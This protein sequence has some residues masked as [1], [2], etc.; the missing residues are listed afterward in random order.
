MNAR[1]R[2]GANIDSDH[3]LVEPKISNE[4]KE[5]RYNVGELN[6]QETSCKFGNTSRRS[7]E[8]EFRSNVKNSIS[9]TLRK[10][11]QRSSRLDWFDEGYELR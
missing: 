3:L 5:N 9:Q 7:L 6:T 11:I 10:Q 1:S 8:P 2:R 4:I